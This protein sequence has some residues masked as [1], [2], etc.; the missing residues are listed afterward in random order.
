MNTKT[1]GVLLVIAVLALATAAWNQ[2]EATAPTEL[3]TVSVAGEAEVRVVPDEVVLTIGVETT[4]KDLNVATA[5]NDVRIAQVLAVAQEHGVKTKHIQTDYVSIEPRYHDSYEK[6]GFIG[7]FVRRSVV[8]TLRDLDHFEPLLADLLEG[9]A[10]YVHGIQFRTTELRRHRDQARELAAEAAKEKA[11][12]LAGSLGQTVGDPL[13]I[14]EERS[15][16]YGWYGAWS[17]ARW[18]STMTQN[19]VQNVDSSPYLG[20]DSTLAPGQIAITARVT[21]QF[22]LQ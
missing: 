20:Q 9:G 2:A 22:D 12:A 11:V 18:G 8:I 1:I 14:S 5:E 15:G 17:G 10:N 21:V 16:W 3:R 13:T 4:H 19:V 7:Y 6:R